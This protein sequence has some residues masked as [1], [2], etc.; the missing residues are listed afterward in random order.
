MTTGTYSTHCSGITGAHQVTEAALAGKKAFPTE[1][2]A[3]DLVNS[4]NASAVPAARSPHVLMT[5]ILEAPSPLSGRLEFAD[6]LVA[7]AAV[8]VPAMSPAPEYVQGPGV[9]WGAGASPPESHR[10]AIPGLQ[11]SSARSIQGLQFMPDDQT[12]RDSIQPIDGLQVTT[13]RVSGSHPNKALEMSVTPHTKTGF[14]RLGTVDESS[15]SY[16]KSYET[17]QVSS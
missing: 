3:P 14:T 15:R 13:P 12:P 17:Y 2:K 11:I 8:L 1:T 5:P 7:D 6:A 9:Y 16:G 10:Q 4:T